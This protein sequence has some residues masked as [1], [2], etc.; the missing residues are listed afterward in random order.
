MG[1]NEIRDFIENGNAVLGLEFGSTR[2]K[3]V[4][5]D[6]QSKP[7]ASGAFDWENSLDNGIWTYSI[8]E[9]H[10]GL[11]TCYANLKKDVKEKFGVTLK[12]LKAMG[13]SAM[14]HGYLAFDKDDNLLVPFRTWRNTITGEASEKLSSLFNYPIP[15]RWSISHLYQAILNKEEHVKNVAFFTTLAGYVH[16]KLTG[17]KV[18]GVGDASGM[19][20]IDIHSKNY[21]EKMLSQFDELIKPFN[22]DFKL[23][24]LLPEVLQA[25]DAAGTL[26][27]SGAK[28]LDKEGDLESGFTFAPPEGDAGT[29]MVATNSVRPRT[30]N[31]S[32][33]TSVFA[34]VVLEKDLS[35][36]YSGKIDL[37]TTPSGDLTAMAHANNCT[38]EYDKWINLFGQ[39][40]E[41][42]G[43]TIDRPKLYDSLLGAALKGDKD[44]GGCI[45]YNYISGESMTGLSE[46]RP[47][48]VRTQKNSFTLANFMRSQLFTSLG[49][50]RTGMNI[51]FDQENV[52]IDRLTGHG[53]FFKTQEAGL[54]AM[55]SAM[56]TPISLMET[57]GEGGPWGM[58]LLASYTVNKNGL[59]L[60][61]WLDQTVF[62]N[63]ST[64]TFEASKEDIEGFN[65]F[66]ENYTKGLAVEKAAIENVQ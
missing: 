41:E 18:L 62:A 5:I 7:I 23:K 27:D 48:F 63:S 28:L 30:G 1:K 57:A 44:C 39:A 38:G 13:I 45:P 51:L 65:V 10:N 25:G 37:V 47:L 36:S 19:F 12:K 53:G 32:A 16:W 20:P 2:I 56:H 54:T 8:E 14:M 29:G 49:A 34:M 42:C 52:K 33:G 9:I 35:K 59:S 58:A 43:F 21:N 3:A 40:I 11:A 6:E 64:K 31:V 24:D 22:F 60:P 4:L 26:T 55:A 17:K 46:G 50:L 15:E 66:F 61:D